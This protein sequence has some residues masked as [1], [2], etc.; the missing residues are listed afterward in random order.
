MSDLCEFSKKKNCE[1]NIQMQIGKQL[2]LIKPHW[3]VCLYLTDDDKKYISY[4]RLS[5]RSIV[6]SVAGMQQCFSGGVI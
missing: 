4:L 6:S 3:A 2:C 1:E 5:H